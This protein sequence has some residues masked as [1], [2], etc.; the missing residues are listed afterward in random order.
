MKILVPEAKFSIIDISQR[1]FSAGRGYPVELVLTGPSWDV[2]AD[3]SVKIRERLDKEGILQDIDT[4]YVL[5]QEEL[6]ILPNRDAVAA[7][8]VSM[9]N[10]GNTIGPLMGG[11]KVS[12]FTENGR[13]YDVRIKIN[14]DHPQ[15]T[16]LPKQRTN[17][18]TDSC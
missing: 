9:A 3:V 1:G 15:Y 18:R 13:S 7:R 16:V 12:R 5:G 10:I 6:R 2:L 11:K 14:K 17:P 4:D 8:G